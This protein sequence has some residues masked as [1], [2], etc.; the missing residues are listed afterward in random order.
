MVDFAKGQR[1]DDVA[2]EHLAE[3]EAEGAGRGCCSSGGRR[4]RR[5]CLAP[6][7]AA[8]VQGRSYPWIVSPTGVV[9]HFYV[10]AVDADFGPFFLNGLPRHSGL[11]A[12]AGFLARR[13]RDLPS[14]R[15]VP[16]VLQVF[17]Y[18]FGTGGRPT[19]LTGAA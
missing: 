12:R 8:T 6:R 19:Q 15:I 7:S 16:L 5:G 3:F 9:N 11:S 18:R 4:R 17:R 13:F 1:K 10:Y 2:H 14:D